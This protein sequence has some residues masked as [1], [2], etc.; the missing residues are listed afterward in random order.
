MLC[1]ILAS[2]YASIIARQRI[3]NAIESSSMVMLPG[4]F[5]I[6]IVALFIIEREKQGASPY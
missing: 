4:P 1:S 5:A 3:Y 2:S 6:V